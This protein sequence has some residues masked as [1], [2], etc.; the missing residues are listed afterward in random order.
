MN[1]RSETVVGLFVLAGLVCIIYLAVN[2]GDFAL[3]ANSYLVYAKFDSVSGLREGAS[4][5]LA[6]VS[7]GRVESISLKDERAVLKL[8]LNK[9]IQLQD[10]AIASIRTKG[11]IGDKFVRLSY[12]GSPRMI[13]PGGTI[14][15]TESPI[16]LEELIQ[17]FALGKIED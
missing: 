12:G 11:L 4:V 1:K 14:R 5:E 16:E 7:V 2:L 17:K 10:D 15:E 6:G 9:S 8:R 3:G 13:R